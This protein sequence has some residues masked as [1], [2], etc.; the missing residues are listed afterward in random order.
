[1]HCCCT[2]DMFIP[3]SILNCSISSIHS[4]GIIFSGITEVS[5]SFIWRWYLIGKKHLGVSHP[6]YVYIFYV[7]VTLNIVG[8]RVLRIWCCM[9]VQVIWYKSNY[10]FVY[11]RVFKTLRTF[12]VKFWAN[13]DVDRKW[14]LL[15]KKM[16]FSPE[17]CN[18][19][20]NLTLEKNSIH[21]PP[22][23]LEMK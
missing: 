15:E 22:W 20:L 19:S 10:G 6:V 11:S 3:W 16:F 14:Q 5:W 13:K 2:L 1:M 12:R 17:R 4:W 23:Y 8:Q 9:I 7:V 18:Y 21:Q